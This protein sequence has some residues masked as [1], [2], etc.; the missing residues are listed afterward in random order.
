MQTMSLQ[1]GNG[2]SNGRQGNGGSTTAASPPAGEFSHSLRDKV[3]VEDFC[4][5]ALQLL[6]P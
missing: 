4:V 6:V 3:N 2:R 1:P 5:L